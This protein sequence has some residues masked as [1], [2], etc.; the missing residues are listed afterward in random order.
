MDF[1]C[2]KNYYITILILYFIRQISDWCIDKYNYIIVWIRIQYMSL[3]NCIRD[4]SG[5]LTFR[6]NC[7]YNNSCAYFTTVSFVLL[8]HCTIW[9][10]EYHSIRSCRWCFPLC[11]NLFGVIYLCSIVKGLCALF[12][13]KP[14]FEYESRLIRNKWIYCLSS[15]DILNVKYVCFIHW[16]LKGNRIGNR[17][18]FGIQHQSLWHYHIAFIWL[19]ECRIQ[20]PPLKCSI[21]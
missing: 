9:R 19:L 12:I 6:F 15:R 2:F 13:T 20:V 5:I 7:I 4:I 1:F 3:G 16:I 14:T 17:I 10:L 11:I 21:T 18:P 8:Y